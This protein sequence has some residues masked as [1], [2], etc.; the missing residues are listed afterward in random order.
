[1]NK[2]ICFYYPINDIYRCIYVDSD[3]VYEVNALDYKRSKNYRVNERY[4]TTDE[5]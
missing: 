2:T 3:D 1:M 4:T 5:D